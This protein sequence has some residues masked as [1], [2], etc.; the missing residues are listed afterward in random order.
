MPWQTMDVEE[1]KVRFVV[2]ATRQD[3]SFSALCR[4]PRSL[5]S[6]Q[7]AGVGGRP[8]VSGL[9]LFANLRLRT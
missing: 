5:R 7:G 6:L 1:Q 3:K 2:A 4:V 8:W 9:R